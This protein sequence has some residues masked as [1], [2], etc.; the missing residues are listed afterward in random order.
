MVTLVDAS[1]GETE[2]EEMLPLS[3]RLIKRVK[4]SVTSNGSKSS[5]S[6]VVAATETKVVEDKTRKSGSKSEAVFVVS[7][8]SED[9]LL[10]HDEVFVETQSKSCPKRI[11][12]ETTNKK[13]GVLYFVFFHPMRMSQLVVVSLGN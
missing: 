10:K 5:S 6:E 13:A 12:S 8:D 3:Q 1:Q 2:E 7:G 11:H 9:E 4:E